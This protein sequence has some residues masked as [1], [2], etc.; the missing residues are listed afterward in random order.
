[1]ILLT[2]VLSLLLSGEPAITVT[3]PEWD[4]GRI[5]RSGGAVTAEMVVENKSGQEVLITFLSTCDCLWIIP[6]ELSLDPG[7]A[8]RVDLSFDPIDDSGSVEK[9]III[10]TTLEQ[11][12][13]ALYLVHGEVIG[14]EPA[15]ERV[16]TEPPSQEAADQQG[17]MPVDFYAAPGCR[18]CQGLLRRTLPKLE[19][20]T[21]VS[22]AVK[23]HNILDPEEYAAYL[24]LLQRLGQ[25]ERT[26]P[27]LVVGNTVLQGEGEIEDH[28]EELLRGEP[29]ITGSAGSVLAEA[30]ESK[31]ISSRLTLLP[32]LAAG[33]LDGV[34]PCAF[35]TLIFLIS[36]LAAAGRSRAQVLQIGLFFSTAVFITYLLIGLG[37]FQALRLSAA[38]PVMAVV[39][40]WLLIAVLLMFAS[41]SLYDYFQLR[42]GRT[43]RVVL[44][45]PQ[46]V[47]RRLHR[48]IKSRA[49]SA[50]LVASALVLGFL[51]SVFELACTGQVYFPTLVYLHQV[52]QSAGSFSYLLLYNFGFILPLLAVFALS[53]WGV[54]SQKLTGWFQRGMKT[55]KLLLAA[56]FFGLA[57]LTL[58]T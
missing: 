50:T 51:V 1:M 52:R 39:I 26:Y 31:R 38:Y 32:I 18:S 11:M 20:R 8:A 37:F 2:L 27:A 28:L 9:D 44:Q 41:L 14:E 49:R 5:D 4:F 57:V 6:A 22:L 46:P 58:I 55:V 53:Y 15:A 19:R 33:L 16:I 23:E 34:N 25:E 48:D 17:G 40:R 3:P 35:T 29:A 36:A 47:K 45:L 24:E 43:D 56:L 10:R 21:G 30:K 54:S 7:Q 12:P 42:A 13:K